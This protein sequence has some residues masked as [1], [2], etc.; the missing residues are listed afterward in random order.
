MLV[1]AISDANA[2][3]GLYQGLKNLM[4]TEGIKGFYRGFV[5]S[6]L[7]I[8]E[9]SLQFMIYENLRY[10]RRVQKGDGVLSNVDLLLLSASSKVAS[11]FLTY[12]YQ[13]VRARQQLVGADYS[14]S[15]IMTTIWKENGM[16]GLYRGSV[17]I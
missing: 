15:S 14:T 13:V 16:R 10:H 4:Q 5:P 6:L 12:P 8:F 17:F 3:K 9:F 11:V 1:G 7:G 2:Y